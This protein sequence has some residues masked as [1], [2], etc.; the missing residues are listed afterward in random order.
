VVQKRER[1]LQGAEQSSGVFRDGYR[2][3]HCIN[4]VGSDLLCQKLAQESRINQRNGFVPTGRYSFS[5]S[6][7]IRYDTIRRTILTCAQ[8][9]T[10]SQLNLPHGTKQ[11][12]IMKKR[13]TEKTETLRRNCAVV[14]SLRHRSIID[15]YGCGLDWVKKKL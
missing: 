10:I 8:K 6:R 3:D 1:K 4:W 2:L 14:K 11:K 15:A 5:E 13:K 9:L 7:T 12:R